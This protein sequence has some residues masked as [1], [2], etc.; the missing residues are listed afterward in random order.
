MTTLTE[1]FC[2]RF[3]QITIA[4]ECPI[5][6]LKRDFAEYLTTNLILVEEIY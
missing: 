2:L 3:P 1:T 5:R 4:T 6:D